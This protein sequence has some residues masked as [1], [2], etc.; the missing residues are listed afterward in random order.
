[1]ANKRVRGWVRE[2]K[3]REREVYVGNERERIKEKVRSYRKWRGGRYETGIEGRNGRIE[4]K[5]LRKDQPQAF[6]ITS[7]LSLLVNPSKTTSLTS[8]LTFPY[9]AQQ[10]PCLCI[11]CRGF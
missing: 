1:M 10:R 3:D 8:V 6:T 11:P 7:V 5:V 9:R 4:I 2:R